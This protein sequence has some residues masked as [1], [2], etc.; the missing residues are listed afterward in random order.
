ME[1]LEAVRKRPGMYIGTTGINGLN[2]LIYEVVDNSVDEAMA[3]YCTDID[4]IVDKDNLCIADNI[5]LILPIH[6]LL[7]EIN[8]KS[9]G[10]N[11]LGTTKK[12]FTRIS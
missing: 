8:E 11:E 7:D 1:W 12:I 6:K 3:G 2:H 9:R 4:I 10:L 5:C